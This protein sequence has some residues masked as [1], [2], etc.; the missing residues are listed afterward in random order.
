MKWY[1]TLAIAFAITLAATG[2]LAAGVAA[3]LLGY[4]VP[5]TQ[6]WLWFVLAVLVMWAIVHGIVNDTDDG[7]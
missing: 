4:N 6:P 3:V 2:V 5:W 1:E 7:T